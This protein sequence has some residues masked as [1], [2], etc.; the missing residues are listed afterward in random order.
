MH[1]CTG[2]KDWVSMAAWLAWLTRVTCTLVCDELKALVMAA[3]VCPLAWTME[4]QK[5]MLTVPL[6][7]ASAL[8]LQ[9]GRLA[10]PAGAGALPATATVVAPVALATKSAAALRR[11]RR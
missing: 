2:G 9:L 8:R 7:L 4:F 1:D 11:E 5:V 6:W 10:A 3:R